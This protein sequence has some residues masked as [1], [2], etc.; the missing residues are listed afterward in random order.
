MTGL[1]GSREVSN[2]CG[3]YRRPASRSLDGTRGEDNAWR[4]TSAQASYK[5]G[6][7]SSNATVSTPLVA[8]PG[9]QLSVSLPGDALSARMATPSAIKHDQRL[10]AV[11]HVCAVA[12]ARKAI[13]T[14]EG[15]PTYLCTRGS[16][17]HA[18][19]KS[20]TA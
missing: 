19:D 10:H 9:W 8:V 1:A 12:T 16:V 7:P 14:G 15:E 2:E 13:A 6:C 17:F 20:A 11:C 5:F 18:V 4:K 3:E